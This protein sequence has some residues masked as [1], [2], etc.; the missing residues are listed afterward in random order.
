MTCTYSIIYKEERCLLRNYLSLI[1]AL[2]N[3]PDLL[4]LQVS[5][6]PSTWEGNS[7]TPDHTTGYRLGE[8]MD[9]Y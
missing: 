9:P 5:P 7:K 8:K 6:L 1:I 2:P 3:H 4:R